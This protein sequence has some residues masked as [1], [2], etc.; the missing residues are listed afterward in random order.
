MKIRRFVRSIIRRWDERL[1]G[2]NVVAIGRVG[3]LTKYL[4]LG[5]GKVFVGS[6]D[7]PGVLLKYD[8]DFD[9]VFEA[10]EGVCGE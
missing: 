7:R 1:H 3:V 5:C 4:C 2:H 9:E 8:D 6:K 10:I